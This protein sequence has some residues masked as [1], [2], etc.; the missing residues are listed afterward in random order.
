MAGQAA[1]ALRPGGGQRELTRF[2]TLRRAQ[3]PFTMTNTP[4]AWYWEATYP[5]PYG[6]VDDPGKQEQINV[7]VAQ[8]LPTPT[9]A[10]LRT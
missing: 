6:Y 4:D 9:M 7:S 1:V 10:R 5:Q 2:F 8:N 3:W